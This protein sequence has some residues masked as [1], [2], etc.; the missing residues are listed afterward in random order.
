MIKKVLI[1]GISYRIPKISNDFQEEAERAL[2]LVEF[3]E[4]IKLNDN[5]RDFIAGLKEADEEL[6]ADIRPPFKNFI[7]EYDTDGDSGHIDYA[8]ILVKADDDGFQFRFIHWIQ[9]ERAFA[10]NP[11]ITT[12]DSDTGKITFYITCAEKDWNDNTP[13]EGNIEWCEAEA[14]SKTYFAA[15]LIDLLNCKNIILQNKTETTRV[16]KLKSNNKKKGT[17]TSVEYKTIGIKLTKTQRNKD[18]ESRSVIPF[19]ES[20]GKE[21]KIMGHKKLYTVDPETGKGGLFGKYGGRWYWHPQIRFPGADE[22]IEKEYVVE[23]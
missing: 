8:G 18:P 23:S 3:S 15:Q 17:K 14:W 2:A 1:S 22:K 4:V 5:T 19:G 10:L 20:D 13:L 7:I 11:F 16:I 9:R 12:I 21:Q 6:M